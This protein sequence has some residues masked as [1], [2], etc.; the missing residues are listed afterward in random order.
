M[1]NENVVCRRESFAVIA[2]D[3]VGRLAGIGGW[4]N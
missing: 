3:R 1:P 4:L 2:A